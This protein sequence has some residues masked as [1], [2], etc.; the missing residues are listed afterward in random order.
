MIELQDL[1]KRYS[2]TLAVDH[3]S[4]SVPRGE[5][6]G[7]LGPPGAGKTRPLRRR[8]G[9]L[10]ATTGRVILG[11]HDL[12]REP[13]LAKRICGFVPD[14]PHV[15]EK[16]TGAEFLDFAAGLYEVDA[17]KTAR[18]RAHLLQLFDLMH[19]Q[20]ELIE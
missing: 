5:I 12:H 17:H 20:D 16:L 13:G 4:L 1:S 18:R 8:R 19:C 7:F 15:Y 11:G 3:L 9:I 6:F 10:L 14:R 2:R